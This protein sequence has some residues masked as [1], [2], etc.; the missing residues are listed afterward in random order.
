[1]VIENNCNYVVIDPKKYTFKSLASTMEN[2][3]YEVLL[4]NISEIGKTGNRGIKMYGYVSGYSDAST[5]NYC[6]ACG[7]KISEVYAD[8][9]GMCTKCGIRFGIV[10]IDDESEDE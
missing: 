7:T 9:T 5:I 8:G 10:K 2:A 1:M 3:G 6:P 4:L